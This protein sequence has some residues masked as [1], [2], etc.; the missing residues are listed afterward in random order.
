M[1]FINNHTDNFLPSNNAWGDDNITVYNGPGIKKQKSTSRPMQHFDCA[2]FD[3]E[4][5]LD[6]QSQLSSAISILPA[7]EKKNQMRQRL[8]LVEEEISK[9]QKLEE[10]ERI[11]RD[12]NFEHPPKE[13]KEDMP[14]AQQSKP[15]SPSSEDIRIQKELYDL[16][17]DDLDDC[18]L[19]EP[20]PRPV[21]LGINN[22]F[23]FASL[24]VILL[25]SMT[26]K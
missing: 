11:E 5:L 9:R 4:T 6:M 22:T 26:K 15:Y 20:P 14:T 13:I 12:D 8:M 2:N 3:Y 23:L 7:C 18:F 17:M 21:G 25:I 16:S 1:G 19:S 24:V 10:I